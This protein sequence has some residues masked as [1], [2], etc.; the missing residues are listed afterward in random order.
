[1]TDIRRYV[2][3]KQLVADWRGKGRVKENSQT[4]WLSLLRKGLQGEGAGQVY[5]F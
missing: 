5:H 3:E 2:A 1:M 4:F